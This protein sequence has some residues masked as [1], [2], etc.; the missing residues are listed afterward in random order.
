MLC[1]YQHNLR[2]N[3]RCS[4]IWLHHHHIRHIHRS[5]KFLDLLYNQDDRGT[6][7]YNPV[8]Q[9]QYSHP[10]HPNNILTHP[11][12]S[13]KRDYLHHSCNCPHC[14]C[15]PHIQKHHYNYHPCYLY[16]QPFD[17]QNLRSH[18]HQHNILNHSLMKQSL[19]SISKMNL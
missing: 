12:H 8:L 14:C 6:C 15:K 4:H 9:Y 2:S 1:T 17:Y 19:T 13:L 3:L 11:K 7:P 18:L 16:I 10:R 5:Q